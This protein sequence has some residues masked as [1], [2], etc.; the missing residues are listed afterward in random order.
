M[1]AGCAQ[2]Q[3]ADDTCGAIGLQGLIGQTGAIVEMLYFPDRIIRIHGP[4]DALTLDYR[5][6]RL[7][8]LVDEGV[9]DTIRC[10]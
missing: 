3:D 4:E 10:G 9:I 5:P 6:E 2:A 7:N 8:I 1:I